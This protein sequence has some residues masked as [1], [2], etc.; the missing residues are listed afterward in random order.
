MGIN[1]E[2]SRDAYNYDLA[3]DSDDGAPSADESLEQ[4]DWQDWYSEELLDAWTRLR[5]YF[6]SNYIRNRATYPSFVDFVMSPSKTS[7][8]YEATGTERILWN[9]ISDI[10]V[11]HSNVLDTQFYHWIGQN[12]YHYSNV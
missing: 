8:T 2:Y 5:T 12:I 1:D 10:P 3:Y 9:L 4:E 6:E 11:I 7:A